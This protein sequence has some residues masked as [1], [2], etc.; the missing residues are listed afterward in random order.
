MAGFLFQTAHVF[1]GDVIAGNSLPT[2]CEPTGEA[3]D[4]KNAHDFI[5]VHDEAR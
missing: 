4:T 5:S 3:Y 1:R 2:N